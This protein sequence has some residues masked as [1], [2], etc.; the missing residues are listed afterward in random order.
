MLYEDA[1][2]EIDRKCM[3][4]LKQ[5]IVVFMKDFVRKMSKSGQLKLD[6]LGGPFLQ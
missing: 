5:E 2:S 1:L 6:H 3:E 4:I